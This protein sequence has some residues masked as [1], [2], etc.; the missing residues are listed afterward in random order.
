[1]K[2]GS[3]TVRRRIR[4]DEEKSEKVKGERGIKE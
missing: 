3:Q 4:R 2:K 1:M